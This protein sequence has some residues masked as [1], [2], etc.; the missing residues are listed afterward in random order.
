MIWI[1]WDAMPLP[2]GKVLMGTRIKDDKI[3][4]RKTGFFQSHE[5]ITS[6]N[7]QAK[8]TGTAS[9]FTSVTF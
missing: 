6:F 9:G 8:K 1:V 2:E 5:W 4:K 3:R 7:M